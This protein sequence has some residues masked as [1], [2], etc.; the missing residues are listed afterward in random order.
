MVEGSEE[1]EE[2]EYFGCNEENHSVAESFLDGGCVVPLV[3][4]F[5]DDIS[6]SL[7]HC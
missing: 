3:C 1:A 5:S 7:I 4:A 6:S 2:E